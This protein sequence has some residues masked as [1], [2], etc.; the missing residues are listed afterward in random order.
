VKNENYS[1]LDHS[2]SKRYWTQ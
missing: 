2:Q 1:K